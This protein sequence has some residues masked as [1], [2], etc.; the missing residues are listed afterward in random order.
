MQELNHRCDVYAHLCRRQINDLSTITK[1]ANIPSYAQR[2]G[3]LFCNPS[4][5]V[6][7][8]HNDPSSRRALKPHK[9]VN[10]L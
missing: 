3:V 4:E 6:V 7:W 1:L 5:Y 9:Q 10:M 8:A 2:S